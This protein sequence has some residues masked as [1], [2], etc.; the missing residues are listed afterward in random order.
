MS[1]PSFKA[2]IKSLFRPLDIDTMK[3]MGIDLSSYE[4]VKL[5]AE[6]ILRRLEAKDMP[7]DGGWADASIDLFKRWIAGGMKA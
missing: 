7:C 5:S 4:G 2:D 1:E 6:A 3:P